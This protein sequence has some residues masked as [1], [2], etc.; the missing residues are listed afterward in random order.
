MGK[1]HNIGKRFL[2]YQL[3]RIMRWVPVAVKEGTNRTL[4]ELAPSFLEN[5]IKREAKFNNYLGNLEEAYVAIVVSNG[6]RRKVFYHNAE[7]RG[8]VE[9]GPHGG[10]RIKMTKK[11]HEI[12]RKRRNPE[13]MKYRGEHKYERHPV[14]KSG[15]LNHYRYLSKNENVHG[16]QHKAESLMR[17]SGYVGGSWSR[18]GKA[19]V[20]RSFIQ[21]RNLAPYAEFLQYGSNR[22][23]HY[24][25]LRGA[26]LD[27]MRG[28]TSQML[29]TAILADLKRHGFQTEKYKIVNGKKFG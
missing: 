22:T 19:G 27:R 5:T 21:I 11:R 29:K 8:F 17:G 6:V 26:E 13:Y 15:S 28:K 2:D 9:V 14:G 12:Y 24:N 25:V 23:K 18:N 3:K 7:R 1:P 16:Y 20:Y 4:E 10:R